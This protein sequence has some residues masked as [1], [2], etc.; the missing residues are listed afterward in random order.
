M[1]EEKLADELQRHTA[2]LRAVAYRMLGSVT[3]ADDAVQEA[4]LHLRRAKTR[5]IENLRAW[6][7]TAVARI[8][9]DML[10][11]RKSRREDF[12]ARI[13][14]VAAPGLDE[15]SLIADAVGEALLVVLERLDPAERIAFV[16]HDMLDVPFDAVAPIVERSPEAT[17]QLASRARRRVRGAP[18]PPDVA[19]RHEVAHAYLAAA[20][21]GDLDAV[22]AVLDPEVVVRVDRVVARG[23]PR[24]LR[25]ALAAA[26]RAINGGA[27]GASPAMVDGEVGVVV[28]PRG[29]LM[30][31]LTL[32]FAGDK[33]VEIDAIGEPERLEKFEVLLLGEG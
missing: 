4:W 16:L 24:E 5:E 31:V 19:R 22:L 28:A 29:R 26:K 30:L 3:E 14:E 18:P 23:E 27:W 25:G 6:L 10:R 8:C 2:H 20:R 21:A 11:A 12:D 15:E 7:T 13:P 33:I 1:D 17:R 9:L 32:K